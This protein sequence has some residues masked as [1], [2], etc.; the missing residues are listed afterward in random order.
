[1]PIRRPFASLAAAVLLLTAGCATHYVDNPAPP[2]AETGPALWQVADEDTTIYLFGTVHALPPGTTWFRGKIARAFAESDE[3]VTEV[4]MTQAESLSDEL[5]KAGTLPR[6]TNLREMMSEEE[7]QRFEL[8]LV[9]LGFSIEAL[10]DKQPWLAAMMLSL[11][12][13]L[14]AGY[15]QSSGV[16]SE[17]VELAAGKKRKALET[18]DDQ[19]EVFRGMPQ[20]AQLRYLN[21]V[22]EGVGNSVKSL[23]GVVANWLAGNAHDLGSAMNAEMKDPVL[24]DRLLTRRNAKWAAWIEQRMEQPGTVF[25]AVGAGHLSGRDS[26]QDHLKARRL[27]VS[28]VWE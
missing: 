22:V 23:D 19:I 2:A 26:V 14:Q 27:R 1:M 18:A 24:Y 15:E 16:E 4:D 8:A 12:P 9:S 25:I 6:G 20:D 17:L 7:R 5:A 10:D 3:M 28:R 21:R 11:V 13:A